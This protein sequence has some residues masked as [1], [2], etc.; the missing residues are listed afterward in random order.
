[1]ISVSACLAVRTTVKMQRSLHIRGQ[2]GMG[3]GDQG[4]DEG[5]S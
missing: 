4:K 5:N 2:K 3:R 1:M